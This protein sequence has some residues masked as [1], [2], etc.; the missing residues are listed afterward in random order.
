MKPNKSLVC[1]R[2]NEHADDAQEFLRAE[3]VHEVDVKPIEKCQ[4]ENKA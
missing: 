2:D 3:H 4:G 1:L